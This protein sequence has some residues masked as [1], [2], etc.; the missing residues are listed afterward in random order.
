MLKLKEDHEG[1]IERLTNRIR[2]RKLKGLLSGD[3]A[4][5][6]DDEWGDADRDIDDDEYQ[7]LK[8]ERADLKQTIKEWVVKFDKEHKRHPTEE[9][10]APITNLL[11][12]H[13]DVTM[14]FLDMKLT[15]IKQLKL[16]FDAYEFKAK[17]EVGT[18]D[19]D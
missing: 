17:N 2:E 11:Q 8:K 5:S 1:K 12:E 10:T 18:N 4:E 9:E 7:R 13:S 19:G 14:K 3:E 16:P 15:L 6:S